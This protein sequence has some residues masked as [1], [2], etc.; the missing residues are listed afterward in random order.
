M[1]FVLLNFLLF[2]WMEIVPSHF[3]FFD[4]H[5]FSISISSVQ[6]G[7]DELS[8]LFF[9]LTEVILDLISP[10]SGHF[11]EVLFQACVEF[12]SQPPGWMDNEMRVREGQRAS[13]RPS[14]SPAK[15]AQWNVLNLILKR[16]MI[17]LLIFFFFNSFTLSMNEG[18][19]F[20]KSH[21]GFKALTPPP[22]LQPSPHSLLKKNGSLAKGLG[23]KSCQVMATLWTL[24]AV[25]WT[26]LPEPEY[27][28]RF[29]HGLE[30]L[31]G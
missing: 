2:D 31:W 25:R 21:H 7:R 5:Y 15:L 27:Q 4:R 17:S 28:S 26:E 13:R 29:A 18:L 1:E 8:H 19:L 16:R 23:G 6:S 12:L 20:Y 10:S 24:P 11:V 22:L 9:P 30:W 14:G 3:F